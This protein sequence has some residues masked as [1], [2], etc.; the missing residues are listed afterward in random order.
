VRRR[1]RGGGA[2]VTAAGRPPLLITGPARSG[3]TLV[4][5]LLAAHARIEVAVDPLF[6]LVRAARDV[7]VAGVR[8]PLP[9]ESPLQDNHGTAA[10]I[11]WLDAMLAGDLRTPLDPAVLD[12]MRPAIA[13]RCA[14]ESPDLVDA[15]AGVR[16]ASV[17]AALE[18]F[19]AAV[20][21]RRDVP[22][23]ALVGL[24]EVW[25]ADLVPAFLRAFP[26]GRALLVRRDPRAVLAS[27]LGMARHDP[28]QVAHP[29]SVLR[30]WRKQEA[31]AAWIAARP[32]LAARTAVVVYE[33]LLADPQAVLAE[34]CRFLG[35]PADAGM[36]EP[37]RMRDGRGGAFTANS[38]FGARAPGLAPELAGRW[39][40]TL[41]PERVALAEFACGLEMAAL[42]YG[43]DVPD[44]D[45]DHAAMLTAIAEDDARA[46]SWR[47][48]L[49]EPAL[50]HALETTR[51]A[52]AG[53]PPGALPP[54]AERALFLVPEA[55]RAL[56][57]RPSPDPIGAVA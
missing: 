24:K 29:L 49:G 34:V 31:L 40:R 47:S 57:G 13:D 27:N 36:C 22:E 26:R 17:A 16:G 11:A 48:D 55:R 54:A 37:G 21:A 20:A 50:D 12:A 14:I 39:R 51:R 23:D 8:P 46:W 35:V 33:D 52:L 2:P 6:P 41:P 18:G 32:A 4:A 42:G 45:L 44:E 15:A 56:A 38:S 19:L 25:A 53:A 30:H 1:D 10:R 28:Q 3:T 7:L 5:R 9:P 43:R